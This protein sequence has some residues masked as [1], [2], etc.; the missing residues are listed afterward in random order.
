VVVAAQGYPGKPKSGG[1]I[2]GLD[3]DLGTNV[4]VFHAGTRL[5]AN[6]SIVTAGGRVLCVSALGDD[7]AQARDRA[8]AAARQIHFDGAFFRHDIGHRAL[9]RA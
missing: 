6:G 3:A 9:P 4:K 1:V 8:Y 7:L 2:S 5:G